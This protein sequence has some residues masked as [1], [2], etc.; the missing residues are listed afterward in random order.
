[1]TTTLTTSDHRITTIHDRITSVLADVTP[2]ITTERLAELVWELENA[3]EAIDNA[4]GELERHMVRMRQT[5]TAGHSLDFDNG[6]LADKQRH[7]TERLAD[8]EIKVQLAM[9]MIALLHRM[10]GTN[11]AVLWSAVFGSAS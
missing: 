4:I 10:T 2:I 7:L 6:H 8:R 11:Q 1:M 5:F 9:Q 3:E